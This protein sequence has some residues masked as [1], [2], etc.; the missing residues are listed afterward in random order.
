M[1]V[2]KNYCISSF[3]M[4]RRVV[5][6]NCGFK[7]GY[8]P[9]TVPI[10]W[11]KVGIKN[12]VELEKHL[13]EKILMATKDGKAALALSG[14]IDSAI[15]ARMM[16]KGSVAYTFKC[17]ANGLPTIDETERA[18]SYAK[19]CGLD[20][21]IIEIT[22]EDM[23]EY[24]PI[25]MKHKN[26]PLHSIEVQIYKA[27]LKAVEDGFER[28]IYGETADVNYGGLS[29]IL[30]R[31]WLVGDFIERYAYLKPWLALKNPKIDFSC[32]LPYCDEH[33]YVNVPKY[34]AEFDII[35]SVNSYCNA[36]EAAEIEFVAPFA[37]TFLDGE[38]DIERVR[39][40]ENKYLIREIFDR[41][42]KDFQIPDKIPMPRAT[43]QWL[44]NWEGP[45][46][47]EFLPNCTIHMN[48]DQK[49]LLWSLEKFMDIMEI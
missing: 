9:R 20:H 16:P 40:G 1:I 15:L 5:D 10:V 36:C 39:R 25:L 7:E 37:D 3:L 29:N 27:G 14:G 21:R 31:D 47:E 46:R 45:K 19:E 6:L 41:L 34:L 26:A 2:D 22:W 38:L 42:Y 32:V 4:Y 28:M 11:D 18:A 30:S 43:D 23:E 24:A 13:R 49:W 17:T 35:E 12:S 44:K 48:G 33:G 8:L